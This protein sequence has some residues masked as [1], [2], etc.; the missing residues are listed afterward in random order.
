MSFSIVTDDPAV[1]RKLVLDL[2]ENS[3]AARVAVRRIGKQ[4]K[5]VGAELSDRDADLLVPVNDG[6]I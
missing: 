6:D 4:W 5:A 1:I 3:N 2:L